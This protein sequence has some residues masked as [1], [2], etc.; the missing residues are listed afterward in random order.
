M[1]IELNQ[2]GLCLKPKQVLTIRGGLGHSIVCHSGTVWLTQDGDVRDIILRAGE[3]FRLEHKGP[4]LLQ[5]IEAG[6]ISITRPAAPGRA[7]APAAL[8]RRAAAG[9]AF[10]RGAG[11]AE[12]GGRDDVDC[13]G[14][15]RG[16][17]AAA[18]S[19]APDRIQAPARRNEYRHPADTPGRRCHRKGV[20]RRLVERHP[21]Q[22]AA[23]RQKADAG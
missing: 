17:C 23:Q 2:N 6:A 18:L 8:A 13:S 11:G 9:A 16:F 20:H 1:N 12:E 14:T 10:P 15:D 5:A 22:S 21:L 19:R 4:A 3:S 7:R